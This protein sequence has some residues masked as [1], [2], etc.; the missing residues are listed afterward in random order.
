LRDEDFNLFRRKKFCDIYRRIRGIRSFLLENSGRKLSRLPST[1]IMPMP[2]KRR[3]LVLTHKGE[4]KLQAAITQLEKD[5]NSG[6][7][8]SLEDLRSYVGLDPSTVSKVLACEKGCDRRTHATFFSHLGLDLE[9]EDLCGPEERQ[10]A[11]ETQNPAAALRP[12]TKIDWG[13]AAEVP[14]FFGRREELGTL[15]NWITQERCK[16]VAVLGMGGMGKTALAVKLAEAAQS[17]FDY[18]IWRSLREAPQVEK[19]LADLIKF[20]SDQQEIDLPDTV[21]EAVTRLIHYLNQ[22]RCLLVLDNVESILQS[23]TQAGKYREGYEGYETLIQRVGESRHQSCLVITSREKPREVTRLEGPNRPVRSFQLMGLSDETGLE[24]LQAEGLPDP[25]DVWMQVV[26]YYSGNPLALKI[27][28]NTIRELFGGNTSDFLAQGQGLFGDIRDL[29][30]QQF[31]RLSKL[32]QSVM[33]WLAINREATS[34]EELKE[35]I[36]DPIA[37]QELL[38][39][40]DSLRRRSLVEPSKEGFTLQNVVMEYVTEQFVTRVMQELQAQKFSL[41]HQHALIK[42]TSKDYVRATQIRLILNLLIDRI[43]NLNG[44]VKNSIKTIEQAPCLDGGYAAGN[45]VNLICQ[46]QLKV[47]DFDFSNLTLRQVHLKGMR[48]HSLNLADSLFIQSSLTHTF[49]RVCAIAFHPNGELLATGDRNGQVRLWNLRS[50]QQIVVLEGHTNWVWS[51]VFS[52][53][54]QWLATGSGDNTIRLWDIQKQLCLHIFE[55]HTNLVRSVAFSPD[56]QWL[57]T[58]SGDAT[59]RLWDIQKRQC[60][61]IFEGHTNWVTS[62]AFSPN[63]R[64]LATGS[65]DATIRLWD[66]QKRQC[67]H[68][69][70]GHTNWI[71]SVVFSPNGRWLATG[72]GDAT[73]RLWDIQK[74]QCLHTFE[75]H[76]N[77]IWSVAF[78]PNNQWLATG[79]GD[80]TI[81]L[82]DIQKRQCLHTFVGHTHWVLSVAFSPDSQWLATG[83]GDATIRLWD[84]QK[85][86]CLHTFEG[87]T[88][89]VWSVAFSPDGQWLATGSDDATIRLWDIQKLQCL[90]TFVGHT[91]WDCSVAFSP[92]G[93]WLATGSGDATIRLWDIQKRQCLHTFEGHTNWIWSV[94]FSPNNQWLATGSGDTTI[95]LWDIQKRQCLH[96]FEGH[97]N[98]V[99]SVAFSPDG[100]WLATGG[101]DI[102]I[103]LWD[104]QKRQCLHTFEGHTNWVRSVAFSP[105]GQWLA[106]GSGDATIRLWDIQKRQCLHTFEGH[107]NWVRSVAFS[108][109]GQWL[110]TGGDD[111][112]IRLWDIQK[113]KCINMFAGHSNW[114]RSIAFSP[115]GQT[116]ASGSNDGTI[117]LWDVKTGACTAVLQVPR[118]Y[119]GTDITGARGLTPAQRS[120]MLALGAID[121]SIDH[122]PEA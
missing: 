80:A 3:G 73:I 35:D 59:I 87:H 98:W 30:E 31:E 16:L 14:L 54:G 57:A 75:G 37:T 11:Q 25:G 119:E 10:A 81:R 70:E 116:L 108:P 68:I 28:A 65:G 117:R 56:G 39:I 27:A 51:V 63:G 55:G 89:W 19:V 6:E 72:S 77:W 122:A 23:G 92:D 29:L 85:R 95:R 40:I 71:W 18:F 121:R 114:V 4:C 47:L 50:R 43:D 94:A 82:W 99:R 64:W 103:R 9:D 96:T 66:I 79:S 22:S 26:N 15:E 21:G 52:P 5:E 105:D 34:I 33:Y 58:G 13:E 12:I 101:D 83:S 107:T 112:I 102:I 88:N 104:I 111:T 36:L 24:F 60:F 17:Q 90:H 49:S 62:V 45:L 110:A 41:F 78:S 53:D 76:T 93:Q 106:T 61:H 109:D 1:D 2:R 100:Q 118:L 20:L 67:L 42:A 113:R 69:F 7:K 74:R 44:Q 84:I 48:V 91:N 46:S 38:E 97:T 120:S 115:D 86:Q 32:G 8:L